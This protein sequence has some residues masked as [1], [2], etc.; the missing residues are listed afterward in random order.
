VHTL[1]DV[2]AGPW[3]KEPAEQLLKLALRCCSF[4]TKRRPAITSKAK[5]RSLHVLRAMAMP[6]NKT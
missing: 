1:L 3:P 6:A 5:W 2:S 4:E